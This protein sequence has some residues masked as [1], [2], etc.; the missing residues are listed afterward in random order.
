[1]R[2][3]LLGLHAGEGRRLAH[4][5]VPCSRPPGCSPPPHIAAMHERSLHTPAAV[6][7]PVTHSTFI[8]MGL[9]ETVAPPSL[10]RWSSVRREMASATEVSGWG[11]GMWGGPVCVCVCVCVWK[12]LFGDCG[13]KD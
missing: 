11:V 12:E 7:A 10:R 3:V 2:I 8:T 5:A 1:M 4:S 9:A 6:P 13:C